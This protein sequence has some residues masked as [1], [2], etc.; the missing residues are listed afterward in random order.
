MRQTH[1]GMRQT[2]EAVRQTHERMRQTHEGMWQTH[3]GMR[4]THEGMW[5]TY[6]RMRQTHEGMWQIRG[7][8]LRTMNRM[9]DQSHMNSAFALRLSA[10]VLFACW[11]PLPSAGQAIPAG[12]RVTAEAVEKWNAADPV[13]RPKNAEAAGRFSVDHEAHRIAYNFQ[14]PGIAMVPLADGRVRVW[15][16]WYQQNNKPGGGAIGGG[17]ISHTVYAYCDDPFGKAERD[18]RQRTLP[19]SRGADSAQPPERQPVWTRV[20]YVEPIA[21]RGDETASDPEVALMPDGRLLC[22][23]ITSGPGHDRKRATYAFLIGNPAA[24]EGTFQLGRQHWLGYGVLSQ[25]LLHEGKAYAVIDEWSVAR[26]FS[27]LEFAADAAEGSGRLTSFPDTAE[28]DALRA[29]TLGEIPWPGHPA[30]TSFFEGSMHSVSGDRWR[31]YRRTQEGVYT[32]LSEPGGRTWGAEEKWKDF[33]SSNSRSAFAKSP[34]SGR[35]FGAVNCPAE[36]SKDRTNLTLVVSEAEGAPGT[37]RQSLNLEP[38]NGKR[39]VA[40]QYPRV[41]FDAAGRVY[42][43]YRWSDKRPDAPHHGAAIV[44]ARVREDLL[45]SG[46]AALADVEKRAACEMTP[47]R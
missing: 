5:Q 36:G 41:A 26:R 28:H 11:I 42:C 37:F 31:A 7:R 15:L 3:E 46:K 39:T 25:P 32:T 13:G 20:V 4:Q 10:L 35:I 38:D 14:A 2:H 27:R 30:L 22:S 33:P 8:M 34:T 23:Y 6:E 24:T 17:S 44:I 19:S 21:A 1:E 29:V 9:H 12:P 18:A 45:V 40:A 43:V 16:T 47:A